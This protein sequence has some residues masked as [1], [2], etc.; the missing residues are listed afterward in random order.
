MSVQ[1][2]R[3]K[4]AE[5]EHIGEKY[6][7][8]TFELL[9][10][11]KIEFIAGQYILLEA[12]GTQQKK[13]YSITSNPVEDHKIELLVDTTPQ[14][15]GTK[16]LM[17]LKPGDEIAFYAPAGRFIIA[18]HETDIGKEEKELV[19]VATGSGIAPVRSMVLDLLQ[20]KKDTRKITVYFGTRTENMMVWQEEFLLLSQAFSNFAYHPVLSKA[21]DQWPLC[22]GRVTDCL[23]IHPLPDT[24]GYYLCGNYHM[25]DDVEKYLLEKNVKKEHIHSEEFF[26]KEENAK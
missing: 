13:S 14:G 12:P 4:T 15:L 20:N 19:F 11:N 21:S 10:P 3:A 8:L 25:L 16:Y 5:V 24:A 9:E 18:D 6:I 7:H 23:S 26:R 2:F 1:R 22:R 17:S